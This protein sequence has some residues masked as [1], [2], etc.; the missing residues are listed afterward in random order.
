VNEFHVVEGLNMDDLNDK[1][2]QQTVKPY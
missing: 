2:R 1:I